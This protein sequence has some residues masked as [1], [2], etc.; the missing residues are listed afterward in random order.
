[1]SLKLQVKSTFCQLNPDVSVFQAPAKEKPSEDLAIS[2]TSLS[3]MCS[4]NI[5][6][7]NGLLKINIQ[8]YSQPNSSTQ[9]NTKL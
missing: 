4:L 8:D 6:V 7:N 1:M 2:K 9:L 5:I 3:L